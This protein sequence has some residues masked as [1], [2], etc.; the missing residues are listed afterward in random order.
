MATPT[1]YDQASRYLV[2]LTPHLTLAWLMQESPD[3]FRF[4]GWMDRTVSERLGYPDKMSD[5]VAMENPNDVDRKS[6]DL[7]GLRPHRDYFIRGCG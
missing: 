5:T 3:N 6:R 2:K 4:E 1:P 7:L